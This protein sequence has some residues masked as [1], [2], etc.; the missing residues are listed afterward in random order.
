MNLLEKILSQKGPLYGEKVSA[1]K[2]V[3]GGCIHNAWKITLE[4][5]REVFVKTSPS[6]CFKM[7]EFEA[8]GLNAIN[9]KINKD[10]LIVPKPFSVEILDNTAILLMP[11]LDLQQGDERKLGQGLA[12][13]HKHSTDNNENRFGWD[14]DGF[15]GYSPQLGGWSE[16]WGEFFVNMRLG[17][18]IKMANKWGFNC[19]NKEIY[20]KLIQYLER[21]N[22][23]PSLVH[24]D[25]WK[26]NCA[27]HKNGKG[28]IFDPAVWFADREVDIAMT[29]LFGG[30]S[31]SFYEGYEEIWKLPDDNKE[32]IDIYNLYHLLNH[33]NL[34]GGNY[35]ESCFLSLRKIKK[36]LDKR[37]F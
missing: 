1:V 31:N 12:I 6:K 29:H 3:H 30:F 34:F 2:P 8:Q 4:S 17:P 33:A 24:G 35:K 16:S 37:F 32:R 26:G 7:L 19:I 15:I 21:H 28:I 10:F 20:P 18:Q 27:I 25:L 9:Q 13:L 22:P 23:M 11:W 5:G 14:T 36:F